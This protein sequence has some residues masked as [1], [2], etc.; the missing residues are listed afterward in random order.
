MC[1]LYFDFCPND[2][3]DFQA[4]GPA[5]M[6]Q[7]GSSKP[8]SR[9]SRL[10][11]EAHLYSTVPK[12]PR[13]EDELE[14]C[15]QPGFPRGC[16]ETGNFNQVSYFGDFNKGKSKYSN[17]ISWSVRSAASLAS[18]RRRGPAMPGSCHSQH[19]LPPLAPSMT[20]WRG[21]CRHSQG[22]PWAIAAPTSPVCLF[23]SS[24][25]CLLLTDSCCEHHP[26]ACPARMLP[27]L[28]GA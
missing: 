18:P 13:R 17:P 6:V 21:V 1:L 15:C 11:S 23:L 27:L 5:G 26:L 19:Q 9:V 24:L 28:T 8:T 7:L 3:P 10:R 16:P 14:I 20:N 25:L 22:V 2:G 4:A 12:T